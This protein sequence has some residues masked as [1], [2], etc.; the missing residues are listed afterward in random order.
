MKVKNTIKT[1]I[2]ANAQR[3]KEKNEKSENKI[4]SNLDAGLIDIRDVAK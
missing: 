2:K 4:I 1:K 3:Q